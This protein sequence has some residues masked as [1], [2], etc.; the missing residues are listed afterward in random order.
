MAGIDRIEQGNSMYD[1]SPPHGNAIVAANAWNG[2]SV[3]LGVANGAI[4]GRIDATSDVIV[5]PDD[6]SAEVWINSGIKAASQGNGTL[7]LT[8][9]TP[10]AAAV[11]ANIVV[12][13]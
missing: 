12:L 7:T 8:C 10:P 11:T 13:N 3:T 4:V 5:A 6:S 1:V 2:N 9:A